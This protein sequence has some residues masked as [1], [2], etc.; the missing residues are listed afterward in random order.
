M[1]RTDHHSTRGAECQ[2]SRGD[3]NLLWVVDISW[4]FYY[5]GL[6]KLDLFKKSNDGPP[7]EW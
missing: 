2:A 4:D 1:S 3:S 5:Q 6:I 7:N